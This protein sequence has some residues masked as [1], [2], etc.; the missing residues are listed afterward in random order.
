MHHLRHEADL[1]L[2]EIMFLGDSRNHLEERISPLRTKLDKCVQIAESKCNDEN[3]ALMSS[4]L[5]DDMFEVFFDTVEKGVDDMYYSGRVDYERLRWMLDSSVNSNQLYTTD[6]SNT[7]NARWLDHAT[8]VIAK[9]A[10]AAYQHK[11]HAVNVLLSRANFE[12]AALLQMKKDLG[13]DVR[14]YGMYDSSSYLKDMELRTC[15]EKCCFGAA[16]D[17]NVRNNIFDIAFQRFGGDI[18]YNDAYIGTAASSESPVTKDLQRFWRYLAPGGILLYLV[19]SFLLRHKERSIMATRY[20]LLWT[21]HVMDKRYGDAPDCQLL[22]LRKEKMMSVD[23]RDETYNAITNRAVKN[24]LTEEDIATAVKE[25]PEDDNGVVNLFSGP[26][27]DMLIIEMALKESTLKIKDEKR[28]NRTIEP[29]LPLKKG[30]IGQIIASGRLN[31]IIDE[32]DGCKHVIAGRVIK[33]H[34][35]EHSEDFTDPENAKQEDITYL[36][37]V[38]EINAIGGD[39]WMKEISMS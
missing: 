4:L 18:D 7:E 16:V 8:D 10:V 20:S 19:P 25:I 38:V 6:R 12:P 2:D 23:E 1:C 31:G 27:D 36:N 21:L 28:R 5:D 39:G 34:R 17:Y 11:K 37:N 22:A 24:A 35:H 9:I 30:Q 14:L 3:N 15:M 33:R 13:M 32:G 29:L 26:E